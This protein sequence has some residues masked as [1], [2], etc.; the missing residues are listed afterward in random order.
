MEIRKKILVIDWLDTYGGSEKVVK[1]L[2]ELYNFDK[3]YTLVN[4]MSKKNL[5]EIFCKKKIEIKTT[6][7]QVLGKYFR[8]GLPLFPMALKTLKIKEEN[9]LIISVSHSVV[10]GIEF[11]K[12]SQHFS[13][14]VAR[15]LK[16]IWEEKPL[17]FKGFRRVF[18]FITPSLKKYDIRMSKR[19]TKT[20]SVSSF[21][22][23]WANK[24]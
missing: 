19:P 14:L 24:K 17:Y 18:S 16:Y 8:Y 22:S 2:H 1:Y 23:E 6:F 12:T 3:V 9:S 4:V 11:P 21:V 15:N 7:L 5:D 20:A 13:Y 10:K